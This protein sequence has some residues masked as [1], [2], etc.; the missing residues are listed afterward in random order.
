MNIIAQA[1][2]RLSIFSFLFLYVNTGKA[3][4]SV[5]PMNV[6]SFAEAPFK[7]KGSR[8]MMGDRVDDASTKNI[9]LFTKPARGVAT[10][11]LFVQKYTKNGEVWKQ[12]LLKEIT[13]EGLISVI[14]N[15][16]GFTDPDHDQQVDAFFIYSLNNA[17]G[18]KQQSIHLLLVHKNEVYTISGYSNKTTGKYDQT[19]FSSN[20]NS[21]VPAVKA[22][23]IKYWEGLEKD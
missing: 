2:L 8:V 4:I 19:K 11:T 1:T 6:S 23:V 22:E 21:L 7:Y 17:D 20:F 3:Q 15:R 14:G 9:F 13:H 18:S 5:S 10:D 16:K 12:V